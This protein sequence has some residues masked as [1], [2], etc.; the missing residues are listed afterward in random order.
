M[1]TTKHK[2]G[3]IGINIWIFGNSLAGCFLVDTGQTVLGLVVLGC[4]VVGVIGAVLLM[5]DLKC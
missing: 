3:L 2:I 4:M 1:L 5:E